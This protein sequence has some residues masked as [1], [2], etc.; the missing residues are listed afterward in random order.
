MSNSS[1][2]WTAFLIMAKAS[3]T[4]KSLAQ[5]NF[6]RITSLSSSLSRNPPERDLLWRWE[7]HNSYFFFFF[8]LWFS[9]NCESRRHNSS[10]RGGLLWRWWGWQSNY[11]FFFLLWFSQSSRSLRHSSN[12]R[13]NNH[14]DLLNGLNSLSTIVIDSSGNCLNHLS[15]HHSFSIFFHFHFLSSGSSSTFT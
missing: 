15:D 13:G 3:L 2:Q 14:N 10:R 1:L 7:S 12:R 9:R 8:L 4:L 5:R 6:R 11:F